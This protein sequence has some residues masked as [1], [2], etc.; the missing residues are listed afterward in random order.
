[1]PR[2][3][4]FD[5][6]IAGGG[7]A[8][9]ILAARLTENPSTRVL[10]LEA[11]PD[12]RPA[13][14]PEA[15]RTTNVFEAIEGDAL[16]MYT[17]SGLEARR[18]AGRDPAPLLRG[19]GLGGSSA[20]NGAA[21]SHPFPEDFDAWTASGCDGWSW[22]DVLPDRIR[23]EN[24]LDYGERPYHGD[25][26]PLPISRTPRTHWRS[27]GRALA[28]A[29][30]DLGYGWADD[31]ND[32]SATG[33][34]P[35]A[36]TCR[37]GRR[38]SV[39]DAYLEPARDRPNLTVLC[40]QIVDRVLVENGAALGVATVG[41]SVCYGGEVILAAG[42]VATPAMLVRSGIGPEATLDEL[43][44]DAVAELPVGESYRDH[45]GVGLMVRLKPEHRVWR[46]D[47]HPMTCIL[48]YSSGLA[49]GGRND[50]CVFCLDTTGVTE[51]SAAWGYLRVSVYETFSNGSMRI[52]STD[53]LAQPQIEMN[54]LDDERDLVRL[55]EGIRSLAELAGHQAFDSIAEELSTTTNTV[56]QR[57]RSDGFTLDRI[58]DDRAVDAFI[59]AAVADTAHASGTCPMGPPGDS[60]RVVDTDCRVVGVESLRVVDASVMPSIPR[61]NT[62]LPTMIVAEHMARRLLR[63]N[64]SMQP[65]GNR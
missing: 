39:A 52:V 32:P 43:G 44:I 21:A 57:G 24:D 53:P 55:R 33:A 50:M 34:A 58:D 4:E 8:G 19:R 6:V 22:D 37:D 28:E 61:A 38:V 27:M 64:G 65:V 12:L 17:W 45:A 1:M 31:M 23:L 49:G 25:S 16:G 7:A 11:G 62:Q 35:L 60:R 40:E 15:L 29:A 10:L 26:G 48:R 14:A 41:G 51:E 56:H 30:V 18:I 54:L 46:R 59:R 20:M 42:A 47:L 36:H 9:C 2:L 13:T 3:P 5:Y 63:G